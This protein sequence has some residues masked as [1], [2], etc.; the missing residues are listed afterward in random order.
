M[1]EEMAR[2]YRIGMHFIP[3]KHRSKEPNLP[4]GN[5][6]LRVAPQREDYKTFKFGNYGIICGPISDICVL[7]VDGEKGRETLRRKNI[8][9][10]H[11]YTPRVITPNDG[12]HF[13]F[14]YDPG[15][16]TGARVIGEGVDI[17]SHGGYVVGPGSE[18]LVGDGELRKYT[19]KPGYG[20]DIELETPPDWMRRRQNEYV[21]LSS[22]VEI[23]DQIGEGERN[24]TFT[25]LAGTLFARLDKRRLPESVI[26]EMLQ[27]VNRRMCNPPLDDVELESIVK[28]IHRKENGG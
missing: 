17:R 15:I 16:R 23:G 6:Y 22:K 21:G 9:V 20:P 12:E 3:L 13:F 5:P 10:D 1:R 26:Y 11:Y 28:S 24:N 4:V 8:T 14:K 25:S 18:I 2:L 19:W 27:V 7:D